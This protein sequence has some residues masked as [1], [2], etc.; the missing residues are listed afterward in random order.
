MDIEN[1]PLPDRRQALTKPFSRYTLRG[2]RMKSWRDTDVN[3]YVDRYETR[4]FAV[5][6]AALL[7]CVLDAYFTIKILH[8]G[9]TEL[10]ALMRAL[11]DKNPAL[12]IVAKYL[13]LAVSI[14]IILIHK[15]F[16]VFGRLKV[17]HLLYAVFVLYGV[18]VSYEAYVVMTYIKLAGPPA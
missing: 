13:G 14:V 16:V 7:L 17:R 2:R 6:C 15:N 5:I 8:I 1:T 9:G 12:A 10:N 18:L 4:Y 11:I 3:Y